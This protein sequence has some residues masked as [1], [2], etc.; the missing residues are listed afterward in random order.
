MVEQSAEK[1]IHWI[2]L[3]TQQEKDTLKEMEGRENLQR[4]N[5]LQGKTAPINPL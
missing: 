3:L 2:L 4:A 5:L 1:T